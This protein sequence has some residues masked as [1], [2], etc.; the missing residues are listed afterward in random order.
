MTTINP[1]LGTR[2]QSLILAGEENTEL[3]DFIIEVL[4]EDT[5]SYRSARTQPENALTEARAT[6]AR[7]TRVTSMAEIAASIGHEL[8]QPLAAIVA[9]ASACQRWLISD[10][11]N[12]DEARLAAHRVTR[13]AVRA[14]ELIARI[15]AFLKRGP[16]QRTIVSIAEVIGEAVSFVESEARAHGV[17]IHLEASQDLPRV[18]AERVQLHQLLWNLLLNGIDAMAGENDAPRQIHVRAER[19]APNAIV[20]AVSDSGPGLDPQ[21]RDHVF[22]PLFTTKPN[23]MGMGLA[24]C[25]SI[26]EVHGGRL[27]ATANEVRGETFRFILPA[28]AGQTP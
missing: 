1:A 15:R 11:C 9:N 6:L 16:P 20:V 7:M 5:M 13:D 28:I 25:R 12:M 8:S 23:G 19:C 14:S 3:R 4:T 17:S 10:P 26:V 2:E 27:W 18:S 21:T 22:E 24:I